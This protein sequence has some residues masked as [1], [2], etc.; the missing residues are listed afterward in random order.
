MVVLS[1]A[2]SKGRRYLRRCRSS[3]TT[4]IRS[5]REA[6]RRNGAPESPRIAEFLLLVGTKRMLTRFFALSFVSAPYFRRI[7]DST[8]AEPRLA[9]HKIVSEIDIG[10]TPDRVWSIL[11]DFAAYPSWNPFIRSI[12]GDIEKGGRLTVSIQPVGG[13]AMTFRPTVL[14]VEPSSELRWLGH[15]LIP[16]I[17]DGEHFFQIAASGSGRVRLTQGETFSG[18]LVGLL[19]ANLDR[20]TK[21]GFIVMNQALKARAENA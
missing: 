6:M 8:P 11:T 13:R 17:F 12:S 9:M 10:A 14:L 19:K 15:L 18:V 21:A 4:S 2:V 3:P 5:A 16:G 7:S 20:G 1:V